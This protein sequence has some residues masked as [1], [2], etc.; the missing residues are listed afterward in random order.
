MIANIGFL[1][2]KDGNAYLFFIIDPSLAPV[3]PDLSIVDINLYGVLYTAK[4]ANHYFR[5]QEISPSRDRC[6]ILISSTAG[7]LD[8]PG[9]PL[10]QVSKFG[11]RAIMRSLRWTSWQESIRVN[12]VAPW[13]IKT[14]MLTE[15]TM[16]HLESKGTPFASEED[17]VK[18]ILRIAS[19]RSMNG[20]AYNFN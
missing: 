20:K 6:L 10:Y 7:Y 2:R 14:P 19:D 11:V 4:L 8:F 16:V 17:A 3:K 13:L 15:R 12:V 5:R 1:A 9:G 18:A